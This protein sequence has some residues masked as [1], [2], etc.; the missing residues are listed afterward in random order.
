MRRRIFPIL[1]SLA[2]VITMIPAFSMTSFADEGEPYYVWV[3]GTWVTDANKNDVLGDGTVS[4]D[5]DSHT[6]TLKNANIVGKVYSPSYSGGIILS[7]KGD[8]DTFTI[9]LEGKNTVTSAYSE[10]NSYGI[11]MTGWTQRALIFTGPGSLDVA[12]D[13]AKT[14][15]SN[16]ISS[17]G[18]LIIESGTIRATGG[19]AKRFRCGINGDYGVNIRGG[20]IRAGVSAP[21]EEDCYGIRCYSG[22]IRIQGG[23][24][25]VSGGIVGSGEGRPSKAFIAEP[26]LSG[27]PGTPSVLWSSDAS[28]AGAKTWNGIP[29][30]SNSGVQYVTISPEGSGGSNPFVDISKGDYWYG[31]ILWAYNHETHQQIGKLLV[32][33]TCFY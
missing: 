33:K 5:P 32:L 21:V 25:Q 20:D 12:S 8:Y 19:S 15:D 6:L 2:L 18:K 31:P 23:T 24:V 13:T 16:A 14:G 22:G 9:R 29:N 27:Y 7:P 17:Y 4:F 26:D 10:N 30:L 1:L 11:L 3:A 28:G